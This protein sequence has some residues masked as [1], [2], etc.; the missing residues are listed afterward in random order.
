[1]KVFIDC[2]FNEFGGDLISM[3][4][5]ADD[6]AEFYEVLNL[7]NDYAYGNWVDKNVVPYLNKEP[8]TKELFQQKL[9]H[10]INQWQEVELIADWPDDIKYF[11]MSLITGP[12]ICIG[13]P[14]KFTM[15]I[16]RELTTESSKVLHN[17][18][19]DARAIRRSW[20]AREQ[21][22]CGFG[23]KESLEWLTKNT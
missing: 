12:G 23:I 17:A 10:F 16:D 5:V 6:G 11:C 22:N 3:A 19:E 8:I 9:W 2:E 20:Y 15:Q 1:M 13:T 21:E 18:L 7:E 4:L 14:Q